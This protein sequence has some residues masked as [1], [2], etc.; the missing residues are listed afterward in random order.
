MK[1]QSIDTSKLD[2][3]SIIV[4]LAKYNVNVPDRDCIQC[5]QKSTYLKIMLRFFLHFHTGRSYKYSS[6]SRKTFSFQDFQC[7]RGKFKQS[8]YRLFLLP[9]LYGFILVNFKGE[10]YYGILRLSSH[11]LGATRIFCLKYQ[12]DMFQTIVYK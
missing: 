7:F 11:C 1:L 9:Q 8:F 3:L 6:S 12:N 4:K 10:Y 2:K 5:S